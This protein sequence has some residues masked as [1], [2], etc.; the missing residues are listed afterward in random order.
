MLTKNNIFFFFFFSV[1]SVLFLGIFSTS[2][3]PLYEQNGTDSSIFIMLGKMLML[4]KTPYVDFFDHKGPML[5]FIE[6][7]GL[8]I[9]PNRI[10][11]FILQIIN[12]TIVQICIFKL[13]NLFS[14]NKILNICIGIISLFF[15]SIVIEGGNLTEEY[16]LSAIFCILYITCRFWINNDKKKIPKY[17]LIIGILV[18]Y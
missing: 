12:L 4:G 18:L 14:S 9:I 10:G 3:S 7:L 5:I 13:V 2:T 17:A 6:A 1:V 11:I 15:F 16:S 8:S